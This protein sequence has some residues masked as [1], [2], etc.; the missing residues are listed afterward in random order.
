[1]RLAALACLLAATSAHAQTPAAP[2]DS[3]AAALPDTLAG[4]PGVVTVP[5]PARGSLD[6][7]LVRAIARIEARPFASPMRVVNE[8]A[9]PAFA[10]AA[11]AAGLVALARGSSARPA[12]RLGASEA[13]TTAVV[14]ALK[15]VFRRP[16]PY[17]TLTGITA[18]DRRYAGDTTR[19]PNSLPSGHSALAFTIAT[20]ATLSDDRLA[21]PAYL[22]ATAVATSRVWHGVHYPSDVLAGAV[23]GAGIAVAV[24]AVLP[25]RR[26]GEAGAGRSGAVVPFRIVVPL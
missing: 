25:F 26:E 9:Y 13:A 20:S 17:R 6:A 24:H 21:I 16:R 2:P 18:R 3:L 1:M 10:A 14:F 12:A 8:A 11:P 23:V 19:D 22:W 5:A 7:R 4:P 15:A